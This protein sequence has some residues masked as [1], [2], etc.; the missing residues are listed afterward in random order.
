MARVFCPH[1]RVELKDL[2]GWSEPVARLLTSLLR[3][4]YSGPFTVH[5]V[6]GEVK[7]AEVREIAEGEGAIHAAVEWQSDP[8]TRRITT[9][10]NES[11]AIIH[12]ERK[13]FQAA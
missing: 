3:R 12:V 4:G 2:A 6:N 11:G 1:C 7:K 10:K 13:V 5:C 9:T 8:M